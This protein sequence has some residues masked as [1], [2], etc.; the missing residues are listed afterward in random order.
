MNQNGADGL[1]ST[2]KPSRLLTVLLPLVLVVAGCITIGSRIGTENKPTAKESRQ[3]M[4]L[5]GQWQTA[6]MNPDGTQVNGTMLLKQKGD[7]IE[8]LGSDT[9]SAFRVTGNLEGNQQGRAQIKLSK[10]CISSDKQPLGKPIVYFGVIDG[11]NPDGP[12]FLH[13]SGIWKFQ[14]A[15]G[16][17][18]PAQIVEITGKWEA[19]LTEPAANQSRL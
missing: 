10:Q 9:N 19:A 7:S 2:P 8:G 15:S 6:Y 18:S 13:I 5:D 12:Y 16:N 11:I 1:V 14:K 3:D 4:R 17:S